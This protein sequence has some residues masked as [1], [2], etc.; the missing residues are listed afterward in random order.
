MY[1]LK[2]N[3]EL[4]E[5]DISVFIQSQLKEKSNDGYLNINGN[6]EEIENIEVVE[7]VV[8]ANEM[9]MDR[10]PIRFS[11]NS[12]VLFSDKDFKVIYVSKYQNN[13]VG[14]F[15]NIKECT[16]LLNHIGIL[17][18]LESLSL[19]VTRIKTLPEGIGNLKHLLSLS[20]HGT[21]IKTF[22]EVLLKLEN[23]KKL[24]LDSTLITTLPEGLGNLKYLESFS[25]HGTRIKT[26]PE[27][28]LKL[29]NLKKLELDYTS[30]TILPEGIGNLKHLESL[31]L[32]E[33]KI[34]TFPEGLLKLENLKKLEL[35]ST[36]IT[37]LPE[38]I[39]NLKHLESLDLH[40]TRI[41][42][43]P[44]GLLK[45]EN[46]KILNF[47]STYITTIPKSIG[48]LKQLEILSL[49]RT[50]IKTLPEG[51]GNLKHLDSLSLHGTRISTLP[52]SVSRLE[53]LKIL[54]LDNTLI[55]ALPEGIG[56]LKHLESLSL[57]GTRI[58]T[59]P[60][61]VSK[62]ENLENLELDDTL[63]TAL[64]E[65]I[66]NLKHL[67][68][69]S[70]RRT[71]I[72]SLPEGIGNLKH[73]ES[74]NLNGTRITTLPESLIKLENL[75]KLEL[76]D[77]DITILPEGIDNLKHLESLNLIETRITTLPESLAKLE[78]LKI[79][80]LGN[81]DITSLPEALGDLISLRRLDLSYTGITTLPQSIEQL[82]N[83]N[84]LSLNSLHLDIIPRSCIR[85]GLDLALDGT[86]ISRQPRALF[87]LPT[88]QILKT[89]YDVPH[90]RINEGKVIFLGNEDAGKTHTILRIRSNGE[91]KEYDTVSTPGVD[92]QSFDCGDGMII[93]FWDFGGQ[94][95]MHS[96]HHCFLTERTC[97]VVVV[98]TRSA[99][100]PMSQARKW[101]RT[102]AGFSQQVSV[103]LLVNQWHNVS[104]DAEIDDQELKTICPALS[105]IIYYSAVDSSQEDFKQLVTERI[106]REVIR[107]DS[108]KLELPE[109]WAGI[110]EDML[111]M[112]QNYITMQDYRRICAKHGLNKDD[113]DSESIRIWL[114]EWFNDMGVCFS[115]HKDAPANAMALR[116]YKVLQPKWLTEGLYRLI[117][118]GHRFTSSGSLNRDDIIS[119]LTLSK[120]EYLAVDKNIVIGKDDCEYVLEV[121]RKFRRSFQRKDGL[122]FI[123]ETLS[124][125]R[126]E[127]VERLED[128]FLP[129]L[130]YTIKLTSL[131]L[132]LLHRLM[133]DLFGYT[134]GVLWLRGVRLRDRNTVLLVDS[135]EGQE[136]LRFRLFRKGNIT[137]YCSLFLLARNLVLRYIREMR[138]VLEGESLQ[139]EQHGSAASY[140]LDVALQAWYV[141]EDFKLTY[142]KGVLGNFPVS[143][144]L[145]PIFPKEVLEG[146]RSVSC[147]IDV[148]INSTIS[149][150]AYAYPYATEETVSLLKDN[151]HDKWMDAINRY[152]E[153]DR[154]PILIQLAVLLMRDSRVGM[155]LEEHGVKK[156]EMKE[157]KSPVLE[158]TKIE[159]INR[160]LFQWSLTSNLYKMAVGIYD[161]EQEMLGKALGP[162]E[163][164]RYQGSYNL[165]QAV[166]RNHPELGLAPDYKLLSEKEYSGQYYDG[167]RDHTTH[168]FKVFL[169]GLYLYEKSQYFNRA[170]K[171][172]MQT[173]K[174]FLAVWILTAMYHDIGYLI[175]TEKGCWDSKEGKETME[176]FNDN[177]SLPLTKLYPDTFGK[178]TEKGRQEEC[179]IR[180]PHANNR[181][182]LEKHMDH[183]K[184]ICVT[185]SLAMDEKSNPIREY[186]Q[187]VSE[188][189]DGRSYYDHGIVSACMLLF[190]CESLSD[191]IQETADKKMKLLNKH[192]EKRNAFLAVLP[193]Y[194]KYA[195]MAA[196]AIA[197][198]NIQKNWSEEKIYD[199]NAR[200]VCISEFCIPLEEL[201]IAYLLRVCD[202]LQCWDRQSFTSPLGNSRSSLEPDKLSLNSY[203]ENVDLSV[204]D[205]EKRSDIAKALE[206][207]LDPPLNKILMLKE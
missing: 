160:E 70:L 203:L 141:D 97:Y 164:K 127:N 176:R 196:E 63:I 71:R 144:L 135:E 139:I 60:E 26:F 31:S 156:E 80:D 7:I 50:S 200:N 2:A 186:Y 95:I 161:K 145:Y 114:L 98:R 52:E 105:G 181:Y 185:V 16:I 44:E 73:L 155:W 25:L 66:G 128:E 152:K 35:D 14:V 153:F 191:Y 40:G 143:E 28:L 22:P 126:P 59:L 109:S 23:L 192:V 74:L 5:V 182:D 159:G 27:V 169:L 77:T 113:E 94:E 138:L 48:N 172:K 205:D 120:S 32:N 103:L 69:L 51:I 189:Y 131:P 83:L 193:Q 202:E 86:T 79:L 173:D 12:I 197:L 122:E 123:P 104:T 9:K 163:R 125:K 195:Q 46:L 85:V 136:W 3:D 183:L 178:G 166:W 140:P 148:G 30:I 134:E 93:R 6:N 201:P 115:Y 24:E 108:V 117:N 187:S 111:K 81:T 102:V 89:Y 17:K 57:H 133:V 165:M 65:D 154:Q 167:Y 206:G 204:K 53:N 19:Y 43:F 18:H 1:L 150:V 199:L 151:Q 118:N 188:K 78:N 91:K 82:I 15:I 8:I 177:L 147:L 39:G 101:L 47:D 42:T 184:E 75:K 194:H 36:L 64:P 168:M 49:R 33:T 10:R 68:S 11:D 198:H 37:T 99:E 72:T 146:A 58:K 124:S 106:K 55:T 130:T 175:E 38:G 137:A 158:E 87:N 132:G 179:G 170:I 62:L 119:I 157:R 116:N 21:R 67:E 41:K 207:V 162:N 149:A 121:M 92:I 190:V 61:S 180:P 56:N 129:P 142:N 174:D 88:E 171:A 112:R 20:L 107:L 90:V 4:L 96:M 34:K 29:E 76:Y 100:S 45:L 54:E 84:M 13:R 110:R